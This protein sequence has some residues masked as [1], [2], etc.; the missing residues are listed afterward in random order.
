MTVLLC[1][2]PVDG[3]GLTRCCFTHHSNP[4]K[5]QQKK[6]VAKGG[7]VPHTPS[8]HHPINQPQGVAE[9]FLKPL[10]YSTEIS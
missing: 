5:E 2:M 9:E 3:V 7:R 4:G 1:S 8:T 6:G 10:E